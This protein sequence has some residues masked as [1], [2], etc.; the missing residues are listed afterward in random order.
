MLLIYE[1]LGRV[2]IYVFW[3]GERIESIQIYWK[4]LNPS[5]IRKSYV[6]DVEI[7]SD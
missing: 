3:V 7:G 2:E 4:F 5:R 1:K 6:N